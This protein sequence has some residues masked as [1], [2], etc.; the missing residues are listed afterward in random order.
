MLIMPLPTHSQK[1]TYNFWLPQYLTTVSSHYPWGSGPCH[2]YQ[3]QWMLKSHRSVHTVDL[4]IP[5]QYFWSTLGWIHRC[6]TQRTNMKDQLFCWKKIHLLVKLHSSNSCCS[7]LNCVTYVCQ[8][9]LFQLQIKETGFPKRCSFCALS[10]WKVQF[11]WFCF[12]V[13]SHV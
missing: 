7:R 4:W 11:A 1:S 3:N 5:K 12:S 13:L 8:P 10:N 6:K 2:G 9:R